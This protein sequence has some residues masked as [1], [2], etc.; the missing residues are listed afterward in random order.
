MIDN[1]IGIFGA[2]AVYGKS[3][4]QSL[5]GWLE[6]GLIGLMI[7]AYIGLMLALRFRRPVSRAV[8]RL[9]ARRLL[10]RDLRVHSAV[11]REHILQDIH[12]LEKDLNRVASTSG[13]GESDAWRTAVSDYQGEM[14]RL[15]N[16]VE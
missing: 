3:M 9:R 1:L 4:N 7:G 5:P 15:R 10:R 2:T 12:R 11:S 13:L 16:Q 14:G 8:T 6:A